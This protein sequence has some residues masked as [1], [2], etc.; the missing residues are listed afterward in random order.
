MIISINKSKELFTILLFILLYF[1]PFL[2]RESL[3]NYVSKN[4]YGLLN[5]F[6][7]SSLL[8]FYFIEKKLTKINKREIFFKEKRCFNK[9]IIFILFSMIFFI[10]YNYLNIFFNLKKQ[11][12]YKI[13]KRIQIFFLFLNNSLFFEKT[14][15]SHHIFSIIIIFIILIDQII[16]IKLQIMN[17]L[18]TNMITNFCYAFSIL[19]MKYINYTYFVS[20]FLLGSILGLIEFIMEL[21]NILMKNSNL[22][23]EYNSIYNK[24]WIFILFLAHLSIHFMFFYLIMKFNPIHS[25]MCS[26]FAYTIY[27][28]IIDF[29]NQSITELIIDIIMVFSCMVYL[30]IIELNFCQLNYNLKKKIED[31]SV[32]EIEKMLETSSSYISQ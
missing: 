29:K 4:I 9:K 6:G 7:F 14:I 12:I 3:N 17:H 5:Y 22:I 31:R 8:I 2:L 32:K 18:I 28:L 10:I 26:C 25:Y 24:L 1:V 23:K 16:I 15:Y 20:I 11:K 13:R 27:N 30:E 21:L 19:L